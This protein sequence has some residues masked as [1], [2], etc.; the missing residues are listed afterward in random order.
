MSTI[1]AQSSTRHAAIDTPLGELTLV[2]DE[3]GLTGLYFPGH[4][5]KP[6]LSSF[7]LRV[8]TSQDH[9]FVDAVGQ[10]TEYFAGE[11]REFDVPLHPHGSAAARQVWGL[12]SAVPYGCTVT[13][14]ALAKQVGGGISPRAIGYFVGHNPL[15]IFI[16]CHRVVGSS[17]GLT[18]YAGGLDRKRHLL[19]LEHAIPGSADRLW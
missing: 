3:D 9:G 11:R 10:L 16:P 13:Y 15:S 4:W 19:E 1:V 2:R 8:E 12:L 6:D 7:G 14:G 5:T 18:G 17:G